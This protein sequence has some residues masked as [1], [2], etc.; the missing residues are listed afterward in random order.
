[1]FAHGSQSTVVPTVARDMARKLVLDYDD[2]SPDGK[3]QFEPRNI[4]TAVSST[5]RVEPLKFGAGANGKSQ[6]TFEMCGAVD[7]IRRSHNK[8]TRLFCQLSMWS[9]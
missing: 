4:H 9:R 5:Q 2:V 7:E 8:I 1:M 6:V 3:I